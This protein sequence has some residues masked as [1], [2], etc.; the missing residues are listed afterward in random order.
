[1]AQQQAIKDDRSLGELFSELANETGTL[2]RHEVALVQT[3]L[4]QKVVQTGIKIGVLAIGGV[5]ALAAL[6]A[7]LTS[8][9]IVLANVIPLW[10]SA[11][12]VGIALGIIAAVMI[13]SAIKML[14]DTNLVPEQTVETLKEDA[15]WLKKQV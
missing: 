1:M 6:M 12:V 2:I 10:I 7:L 13:A 9:I 5:L 8:L 14:K 4:T 3:E 15:Q 11:L